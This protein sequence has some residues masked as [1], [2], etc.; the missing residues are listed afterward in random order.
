MASRQPTNPNP[1]LNGTNYNKLVTFLRQHYSSKLGLKAIPERME[2]RV[3]KTVQHY[4]TEIARIQGTTKAL[5]ALNQEVLRETTSSIDNWLKKQE[6]VPPPATVSVGNFA[7]DTEYSRLF[8]DTNSRYESMLSERAPVATAPL[9]VPDFRLPP[10]AEEE[11]D[12]VVLMQRIQKQRDEQTRAAS[13][14]NPPRLQIS[15]DKPPS[16]TN[17]VP[18][19]AEPPPPALAPRQQDYIIPQEDIVKYRETEH[20]IFLTSSDRDWARNTTENRYNFSVIFN[21][22]NSRSTLGYNA[23]VQQRFRNI[24]RIEFVKAVVPIEALVPLVRVANKVDT[25]PPS[26]TVTG[27]YDTSRVVN[28]FALPFVSVRIAELNNNGFSTKPE[29]DNTFAIV[30]YD[31]TW[32]SDIVVPPATKSGGDNYTGSSTVVATK[33]GYTGLIPK[34]LKSQRVYTPTPLASLTKLSIRLERHTTELLNSDSD[35]LV[36]SRIFLSGNITALGTDNTKYALIT[37]PLNPYIF[38]K[39][40]NWFLYSA[41]SE[42]DMINLQGFTV[43]PASGATQATCDDFTAYINRSEGHYVVAVGYSDSSNTYLGRNDAG[44]C[45]VIIIRSRFDDP[46]TTGG[47]TRTASYYGGNAGQEAVGVLPTALNNAPVQSACSLIN[48][49]RQTHIVLRVITRDFDSGSNIRP[50]NV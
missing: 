12:P 50:D 34:F 28:V 14:S 43:S 9:A 38:I 4:M 27:A 48:M 42:G 8:E 11:E 3:Q 49:S 21:T 13:N 18:I 25:D 29:E 19:Q 1:F 39:T 16:S 20:N 32:S 26:A 40:T 10:T 33:S 23:A 15:D 36:V 37:S 2:T 6:A 17:P 30:Q 35:V 22:G 44:Y 7:K 24:Q 5:P 45:N 47:T 46:T 41:V 31:T